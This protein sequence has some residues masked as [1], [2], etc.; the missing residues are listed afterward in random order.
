MSSTPCFCFVTDMRISFAAA[1]KQAQ[2]VV[3]F[4]GIRNF[5]R[6]SRKDKAKVVVVMGPTGTGKSR[7]SIDLATQFRAE[8]V[9][10]DKMQVYKGLD[11]VADKLTNEERRGIPHHA[12]LAV[13]AIQRR[14]R[15]P[16]IAGGS[17]SYIRAL[18]SDG[19]EFRSKYDC[20][21]LWVDVSLPVL[22]SFVSDRADRMVEIGLVDEIRAI[23]FPNAEVD[24][25]L[26]EESNVDE[27]TKA[28]MLK[29]PL[30]K[31]STNIWVKSVAGPSTQLLISLT[32]TVVENQVLMS[33]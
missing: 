20:C 14:D 3:S 29:R 6:L 16:I 28:L 2:P 13:E 15:L 4:R 21:F 9:N 7:L 30:R 25:F 32:A 24:Q 11:I 18:V 26:R 10:S 31:S 17:N 23:F 12:S 1:N 8:I 19:I 33:Y 5:I 27:K 22:H